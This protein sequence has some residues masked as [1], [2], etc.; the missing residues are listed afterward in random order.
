MF[1]FIIELL[2]MVPF[3]VEQNQLSMCLDCDFRLLCNINTIEITSYSFH[4]VVCRN[5]NINR[6]LDK[7]KFFMMS[8]VGIEILNKR[9]AHLIEMNR[10]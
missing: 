7:H 2:A 5:I 3:K 1:L 8:S 4:E 10:R 6:Q 9:H